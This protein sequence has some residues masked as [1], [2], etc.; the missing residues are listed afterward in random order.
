MLPGVGCETTDPRQ[1]AQ[2][3][4]AQIGAADTVIAEME[5]VVAQAQA[6]GEDPA[7]VSKLTERLDKLKGFKA[8]AS[9]ALAAFIENT[10]DTTDP[11]DF[12]A[13]GSKGVARFLPFPW[14]L[15][16]IGVGGGLGLLAARQRQQRKRLEADAKSLVKAIEEAKTPDGTVNFRDSA[17]D[18]RSRMSDGAKTLVESARAELPPRIRPLTAKLQGTQV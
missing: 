10:A 17:V 4:H 7:V 11:I 18:L 9:A 14:D 1:A 13:E 16:A 15:V 2:E 6:T 12:A 5:A 8:Q 3:V